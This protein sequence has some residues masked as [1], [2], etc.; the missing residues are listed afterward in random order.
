M[1]E[2][3]PKTM[4]KT[5][6]KPAKWAPSP[7][8]SAVLKVAGL[9]RHRSK[10]AIASAAGVHRNS[11]DNW[12][13]DDPGFRAAWESL[14]R[15]AAQSSAHLVVAAMVRKAAKGDVPAARLVCELAGLAKGKDG[16]AAPA[17]AVM[18]ERIERVIVGTENS[19]G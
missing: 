11:L 9:G 3:V 4:E 5:R 16:P 2:N 6:Q 14:W 10:S 13:R 8:Q 15:V 17:G 7:K 12:L 18:I 19:D 1:T